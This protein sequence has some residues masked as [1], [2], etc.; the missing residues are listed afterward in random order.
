M[1]CSSLGK[2]CFPIASSI[3]DI[4]CL[5]IF[6]VCGIL[7]IDAYSTT[8][9][10]TSLAGSYMSAGDADGAGTVAQFNRPM[11]TVARTTGTATLYIADSAND[12]IKQLDLYSGNVTTL[13]GKGY[14]GMVDGDAA[15]A[16]FSTPT[17]LAL[18]HLTETTL[19]VADMENHKIRWVAVDTGL[20][21][22]TVGG[23]YSNYPDNF[24]GTGTGA[25]VLETD[26][27]ASL[28]AVGRLH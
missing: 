1:G 3:H 26:T 10:S 21:G 13:A 20:T 16:K 2:A 8:G 5:L 18:T 12:K 22:T 27:L 23:G 7:G 19:Y 15:V 17:G 24:D 28:L 25:G 4:V 14:P 6:T 9:V 11:G